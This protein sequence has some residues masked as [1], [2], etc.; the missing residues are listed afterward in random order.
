MKKMILLI[1][2]AVAA[3]V[4]FIAI[5]LADTPSDNNAEFYFTRLAYSENGTRGI[6]RFVPKSFRCP[7]FGGGN[8]F[9]PQGLGWSMDSPG[10]DCKYMGGIQLITNLRLFPNPNMIR[11]TDPD[12]FKYPYAY[13]V[14]PGGLDLTDDEVLILREYLLRGGFIHADDFWGLREKANFED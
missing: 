6:G 7:E 4:G 2:S 9:P 11:I 14:E 1:A 10:A 12:L 13:I 5:F 8:F 3:S